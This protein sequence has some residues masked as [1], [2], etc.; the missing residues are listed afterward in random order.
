MSTVAAAAATLDDL[1]ANP[2]LGKNLSPEQLDVLGKELRRLSRERGRRRSTAPKFS[3][4]EPKP[5]EPIAC[6]EPKYVPSPEEIAQACAEIRAEWSAQER[7]ERRVGPPRKPLR[8]L[9]WSGRRAMIQEQIRRAAIAL[10][11]EYAAAVLDSAWRPR[12]V[13]EVPL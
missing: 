6:R 5:Y 4:S 3:G 1:F 13:A 11:G 10:G 9:Y 7:E 8:R 2:Q 12:D